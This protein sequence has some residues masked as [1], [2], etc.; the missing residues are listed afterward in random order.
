[1]MMTTMTIMAT[2]MMTTTTMM[3]IVRSGEKSFSQSWDISFHLSLEINTKLISCSNVFSS[4]CRATM[5]LHSE[6]HFRTV[7]TPATQTDIQRTFLLLTQL[8]SS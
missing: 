4:S 2:M 5:P 1:M 8:F 3:M 7:V 6:T